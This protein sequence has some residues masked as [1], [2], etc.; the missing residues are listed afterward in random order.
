MTKFKAFTVTCKQGDFDSVRTVLEKLGY[1]QYGSWGEEGEDC[2]TTTQEGEFMTFESASLRANTCDPVT[3]LEEFATE[4]GMPYEWWIEQLPYGY[5]QRALEQMLIGRDTILEKDMI[6][7]LYGF[8]TWT[9]TNEGHAFWCAV[10][11]HYQKGTS[12]P[13]LPN[14]ISNSI[15]EA[16]KPAKDPHVC[17]KVFP[18]GF[19]SWMETHQDICFR[20]GAA[21]TMYDIEETPLFQAVIA[22]NGSGGVYELIEALTDIFESTYVDIEDWGDTYHDQIYNFLLVSV[23]GVTEEELD[24][25]RMGDTPLSK[26]V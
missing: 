18:N 14:D 15:N 24:E 22:K 9:H 19:T 1:K 13:P 20:I 16:P 12:L 6:G 17:T 8:A 10:K 23:M 11:D 21:S 3:T 26:I 4:Y 2:I 7:A 5:R 25:I